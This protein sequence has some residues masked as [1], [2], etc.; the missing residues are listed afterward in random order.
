MRVGRHFAVLVLALSVLA[1]ACAGGAG[2][3][4]TTSPGTQP[5]EQ[6]T[7]GTTPGLRP[8]RIAVLMP[9]RRNDNSF[10]QSAAV[11]I[12]E[13]ARRDG[14]IDVT[15][16]DEIPDPTE[17]E[18]AIRQFATQGFDLIIGHGIEYVEP[19][20]TVAAEFPDVNFMTAAAGA[21]GK[22]PTENI[23]DWTYDFPGMGYLLGVVAGLV[24]KSNKVG[25]VG[26]P[27]LEFVKAM[28]AGFRSGLELVNPDAQ[29]SELFAGS[30][31][32][33]QAAAE[34]AATLVDGGADVLYCSGDGICQGVA[35]TAQQRRVVLLTGFG[36]LSGVA[37]D[38]ALT[39][40]VLDLVPLYEEFVRLV[41][42]DQWG[43]RSFVS[44]LQNG[45][46]KV[47]RLREVSV[48]PDLDVSAVQAR[49]DEVLE[50][51]KAGEIDLSG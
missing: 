33:A 22:G 24:T 46:E 15:I 43:G 41:R 5:A 11:A 1:V 40:T 17:S 39:A 14:N 25:I 26:G 28:H 8:L 21:L 32:D 51:I 20:N 37:P 31:D 13:V 29:A 18:P 16:L 4:M 10:N 3:P 48:R 9:G 45:Q 34:A 50:K 47:L 42:E 23:N 44:D 36:D 38:V 19:I 6:A 2:A 49:V 35:Q 7:G 30:F 27:E 12:E